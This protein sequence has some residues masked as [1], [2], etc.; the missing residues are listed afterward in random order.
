MWNPMRNYGDSLQNVHTIILYH[1]SGVPKFILR[2]LLLRYSS[3]IC[4]DG[5]LAQ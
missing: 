1:A 4:D 2:D 3:L 5:P